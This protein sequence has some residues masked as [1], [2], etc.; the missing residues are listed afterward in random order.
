M[1]L[2]RELPLSRP[3]QGD[4]YKDVTL[5]Q[6]IIYG[7]NNEG[8]KEYIINEVNYNYVIILSQECDLEQDLNNR[9]KNDQE[10]TGKD[11]VKHDK[12]IPMIL[13]VPAYLAELL[14]NGTHLLEYG[15]KMQYLNREEWNKII[16]NNNKRYHYLR[17]NIDMNVPD[18]V[19]DFKH[20][21]TISRALFYN[22]ILNKAYHASLTILYREELSQRF[23][24]YFSRIGILTD[25][26]EAKLLTNSLCSGI[27][28]R[29]ILKE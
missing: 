9:I 10:I 6:D 2:I 8:E 29:G 22:K 17:S 23:C 24:N 25:N 18:I 28:Q 7:I 20:F 11:R 4:I 19:V 26:E 15:Q 21:F 27:C 5:I 13:M 12:Y 3:W 1:Y 14:K 16:N